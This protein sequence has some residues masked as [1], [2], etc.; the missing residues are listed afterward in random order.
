MYFSNYQG[1]LSGD[2]PSGFV[3]IASAVRLY[4]CIFTGSSELRINMMP[5]G[6]LGDQDG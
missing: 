4:F 6:L 3:A 5:I 2:F 1:K